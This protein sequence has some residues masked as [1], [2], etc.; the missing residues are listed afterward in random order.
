MPITSPNRNGSVSKKQLTF[1]LKKNRAEAVEPFKYVCTEAV[2]YGSAVHLNSD[3]KIEV[4][5]YTNKPA[6]AISVEAGDTDAII[7]V[8]RADMIDYAN[9]FNPGGLLY[10]GAAGAIIEYDYDGIDAIIQ[11]IAIAIDTGKIMVRID[12]PLYKS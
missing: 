12:E 9:T 4:A 6:F 2:N 1:K 7:E 8:V 10:L 3:G 11:P 5:N